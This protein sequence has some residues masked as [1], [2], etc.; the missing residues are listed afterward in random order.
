MGAWGSFPRPSLSPLPL[1]QPRLPPLL[2]MCSCRDASPRLAPAAYQPRGGS[3]PSPRRNSH[4]AALP[5]PQG[6][7]MQAAYRSQEVRK[8]GSS[9]LV[10]TPSPLNFE[11]STWN[12]CC[13]CSALAALHAPC[14]ASSSPPHPSPTFTHEHTFLALSSPAGSAGCEHVWP[15]DEWRRPRFFPERRR[16]TFGTAP[17][18]R[19]VKDFTHSLTHSH[20]HLG[21]SGAL[22]PLI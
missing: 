21:T 20:T 12:G 4:H 3:G 15:Q 17:G 8:Q 2:L 1:N 11:P 16:I 14:P 9:L 7:I 13:S 22:S 5:S 6:S 18:S 10:A 19:L